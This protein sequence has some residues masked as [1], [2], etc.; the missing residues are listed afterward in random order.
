ME[1]VNN[2][3]ERMCIIR[4]W[5]VDLVHSLQQTSDIVLGTFCNISK[6]LP[7]VKSQWGTPNRIIEAHVPQHLKAC[8][9]LPCEELLVSC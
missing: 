8:F 4:D 2:V 9:E 6:T 5:F 3:P 1:V 7:R